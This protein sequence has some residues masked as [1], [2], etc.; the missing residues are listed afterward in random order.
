MDKNFKQYIDDYK[1]KS[2]KFKSEEDVRIGTNIFLEILSGKL[3]FNLNTEG[4]E[5]TSV[6]GGRADSVYTDIIVEYKKTNKFCTQN[7]ISEAIDGRNNKDHGLKHYLI[8]FTLEECKKGNDKIFIHNLLNK[9]GIGFDGKIFIIGRYIVTDKE[10]DIFEPNKTSDF[11]SC[12][13]TKQKIKFIYEVIEDLE[14]GFKKMIL[15]LRSTSRKI[16]SSKNLIKEF[17][18]QSEVCRI[19]VKYL[20]KLLNKNL[21]VNTRVS[22]LYLEWDRIFGDLYGEKETEFNKFKSSLCNMYSLEENIELKKILFVLQTYYNIIL[23]MLVSNLLSSLNDPTMP[24]RYPQD[25]AELNLLFSGK[26]NSIN[27]QIENFFEIHFFEWFVYSEEFNNDIIYSIILKLESIETTASVI[28]PE[29]IEDVLREMYANLMPRELRRLLGEYYTPG[30]L[31]DFTLDNVDY[32][33]KK[34]IT[35][36]DPTCGSGA[37]ITHAIKRFKENNK[38][39]NNSELINII[40]KNIVGYDIN[41]IAVISAKTNYILALGDLSC[42]QDPI[43]VPIYMCDSVLVPTIHAKQNKENNS[44]KVNTIVGTFEIPVLRNRIESDMFLKSIAQCVMSEQ[45]NFDEFIQYLIK[46]RNIS[47]DKVDMDIVRKFFNQLTTLHAC[48]KNGYWGIIL[49]NAFA[50]LFVE[51][52]FDIIVGNPPWISWKR[53]SDTYRKQTL[54]IWLS[55]GIFNKSAYEKKTTHDDFAMAV[56]YVSIDHYC[57]LNGKVGFILPQTFL[58]S[59]KGGDGFRKFRITRDGNNIPF[60]VSKVYDFN[61]IKPFNGFASNRSSMII[62]EK[63]KEMK[64][65]MKNYILCEKSTKDTVKYNDTYNTAI[66]K[67]SFEAYNAQP[68]NQN[69]TSPWLTMKESELSNQKKYLGSSIYKGRKGIEPCGA[70]GIYLVSIEKEIN[71]KVIISNLIERSRLEKAKQLGVY[72]G[73]VE[74]SLIYPIIGGRDIKR[75][76]IKSYLYMVVPHY[77]TGKSIYTGIPETEMKVNYPDTFNWLLYFKELLLETRIRN[78]KYFNKDKHPFYRLDN[79]GEYTFDSYRVVWREQNKS[80]T[81]CVIHK[82]NDPILGEKDLL[83]DSKVLSC[84]LSS[85]EEA[86]YLCAILNAPAISRLIES[87]TIDTQR[88]VDILK[89]IKIPGFDE[90]NKIH[91]ELSKL[92]MRAHQNYIKCIDTKEIE[93]KIDEKV[94]KLFKN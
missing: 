30:W 19:S 13:S 88:G 3:N 37:F 8:N 9:V 68:I 55:Y 41:P 27:Y 79:V 82:V 84:S 94:G 71:N 38:G 34:D 26:L 56:T 65:P 53:M 4:H 89:N 74:K 76:G 66:S 63:N 91:N 18:P 47:F 61:E 32:K 73:V 16:L 6:Y 69:I 67:I 2:D 25:R 59:S 15:L 22:T 29:M 81:A 51:D 46:N 86:H 10:I 93:L 33:G 75:W 35:I 14:L 23:K 48:G 24:T 52:G 70:K 64:Y 92:S 42:V 83:I 78:G 17:G 43:L 87:Y 21:L 85:K 50:P 28:R 39:L 12:I 72:R 40:T 90:T 20:Y 1:I 60:K 36:L 77:N 58:K 7:G 31:V 57:K 44:I 54:D 80:M 62:F 45:Y 11:P 5:V 49:K